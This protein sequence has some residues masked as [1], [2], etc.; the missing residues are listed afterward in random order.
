MNQRK[1]CQR[2]KYIN[3]VL[4]PWSNLRIVEIWVGD[5]MFAKYLLS[6]YS[7]INYYAWFDISR[8][9]SQDNILDRYV[10]SERIED[11]RNV[12]SEWKPIDYVIIAYSLHHFSDDKTIHSLINF[13]CHKRVWVL[14]IEELLTKQKWNKRITILNDIV[15]NIFQYGLKISTIKEYF[16]LKFKTDAEWKVIFTKYYNVKDLM[17]NWRYWYVYTKWYF[18]ETKK[19]LL[20]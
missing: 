7:N 13:L 20:E 12:L 9:L 15:S 11:E 2:A 8:L 18:L 16:S 10:V 4:Q 5:G 14:V 19:P 1:Q 3:K 17:S 6:K